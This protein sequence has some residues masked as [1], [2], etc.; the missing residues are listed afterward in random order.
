MVEELLAV[1]R[2]L[3]DLRPEEQ[4]QLNEGRRR[5]TLNGT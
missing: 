1:E 2:Q 4:A 3:G 5:Q